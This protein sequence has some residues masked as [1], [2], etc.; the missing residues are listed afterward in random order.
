MLILI[1]DKPIDLD[2]WDHAWLSR[3]EKFVGLPL[4]I[5]TVKFPTLRDHWSH[6][7]VSGGHPLGSNVMR[8]IRF[9]GLLYPFG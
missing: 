8:R 4:A 9:E 5:D 7:I 2:C 1:A 6:G 3:N